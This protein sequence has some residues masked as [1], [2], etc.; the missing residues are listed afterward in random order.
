M[1]YSD[2]FG[3]NFSPT[4][5]NPFDPSNPKNTSNQPNP[6]GVGANPYVPNCSNAA[7]LEKENHNKQYVEIVKNYGQRIA[8]QPVAYNVNTHNFLYGEDPTSGY[9]YARY[10]KAIVDFSSYNTF[11][12]KFG[13][14][15][16]ADVIIYVPI[17]H[18]EEIW[19]T[20][21]LP[22]AG[23]IFYIVDSSCDRPYR[24]TPMVFEVT[25]KHDSINPVDYMGG[26][27]VWKLTARRYD[28]SYEPNAEIENKLGGPE[29]SGDAGRLAGG[30]NEPEPY[31]KDYI[32]TN[33]ETAKEDFDNSI[34]NN[35]I[36]GKYL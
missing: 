6:Y 2:T 10:M 22:L 27:Y 9:H 33:D 31:K 25:E 34:V 36:Y 26:H 7:T 23:D 28:Y 24:Q 19:G 35:N 8:Y 18:F 17:D 29:D 1:A 32:Q 4:R 15:S 12:T 16:D 3:F 21:V 30:A 5:T 20:G 13:I 11:M 14:M